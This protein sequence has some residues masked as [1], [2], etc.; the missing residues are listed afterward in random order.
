MSKTITFPNGVKVPSLGQGTWYMG[1]N[2]TKKEEEIR[3][4][5]TGV[6]LG[7]TVIDTA[8]MY[9]DGLSEK[10]IGEAINGL[11]D[12]VFLISKVFPWN[13]NLSGTIKACEN[14]LRRLNTDHLDL[15]LLH[16]SG[17]YPIEETV[18]AMMR[19][20][21]SGKILQWGVSNMDVAEME[22]FMNVPSGKNCATDEILYNLT[23]RGV[24]YDLLPWCES[25]SIPVIAYS[26]IEQ[27]RLLGNPTLNKIAKTHSATPA[28]IALAWVL[29]NP[30]I[31]AIPKASSEKHVKENFGSLSI[32]LTA[33]D[34]ALL[35][36][37]FSTPK[38]KIPLEMI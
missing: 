17:S 25:H 38:R 14:S 8:E 1:E 29:R 13:A 23:R 2:P 27:G 34:I 18:E 15:Y 35:D 22:D 10:L 28:Q 31:L 4:I 26:P 16:W 6:E 3:A 5:R 7:M 19:L 11:R 12:D 30:N 21:Q 9:G 20:Q 33:E 37:A 32:N 24:E 36:K